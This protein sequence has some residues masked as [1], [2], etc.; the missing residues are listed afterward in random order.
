MSKEIHSWILL[1]EIIIGN[2]L[3]MVRPA[4]RHFATGGHSHPES[5]AFQAPGPVPQQGQQDNA[6]SYN[7]KDTTSGKVTPRDNISEKKK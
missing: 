2:H 6:G 5:V 1:K 4:I 7:P 3:Q